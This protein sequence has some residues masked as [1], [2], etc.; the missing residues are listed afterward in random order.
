MNGELIQDKF[1]QLHGGESRK[2]RLFCTNCGNHLIDYQ[3]DGKGEL[4]RCYLN[5]ILFPQSFFILSQKHTSTTPL[6][7]PDLTCEFCQVRIGF[8]ARHKDGRLCFRLLPGLFVVEESSESSRIDPF[9]S[10]RQLADQKKITVEKFTRIVKKARLSMHPLTK[11]IAARENNLERKFRITRNGVGKLITKYGDFFLFDFTIDDNWHKYSV[12]VSSDLDDNLQPVFADTS[13]ILLRVDSG[14]ETGQLFGDQTCECRDQLDM[15]TS[16]IQKAGQGIIV[17]IPSHDGRGMGLPFKL[18]TLSLQAELGLNTVEA[19]NVLALGNNIDLRT[20]SG[21]V[22]I[23][24]FF[25]ITQVSKISLATNNPE[26]ENVFKENGYQLTEPP[27]P[28]VIPPTE[29]TLRHLSA[30]Q[31]RLGHRNL[32]EGD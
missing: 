4:Y 29:H 3:K 8:P 10:S 2:I 25:G 16:Y 12:L 20:Y 30:K 27:T 11:E 28:V 14:C 5:R 31:R 18:A 6:D 1:L 22:C 15:A 23:L 32:I 19:A 24:K 17:H 9:Q 13:R 7:L 21:V 26:K